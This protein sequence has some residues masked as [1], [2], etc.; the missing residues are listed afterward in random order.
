MQFLRSMIMA[1]LMVMG[2][3]SMALAEPLPA[4]LPD[5]T[6]K[7]TLPAATAKQAQ[8]AMPPKVTPLLTPA[9]GAAVD[10][11]EK[12]TLTEEVR[13]LLYEKNAFITNPDEDHISIEFTGKDAA[14][15]LATDE[16]IDHIDINP[17][18]RYFKLSV[19]DSAHPQGIVIQGHYTET[20]TLPVLVNRLKAGDII[21][22]SDLMMVTIPV[23]RLQHDTV[24][25][26][27]ELLGKT[28]RYSLTTN[29]PINEADVV[30]PVAIK[31]NDIVTLVYNNGVLRLEEKD[32][33]AME[34]GA[35]GD[36]I[37]VKKQGNG[38]LQGIVQEN[39]IVSI[40]VR[41]D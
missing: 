2:S 11:G 39:H 28:P 40:P 34:S 24:R 21:R 32:A 5:S 3:M 13:D 18:L 1:G 20:V 16:T 8:Q 36:T 38:F 22:D 17:S 12:Q 33:I 14:F 37:K 7:T 19:T 27:E 31:K 26:R 6:L 15:A 9:K 30:L 41:S 25:T 29:H 4:E 10:T 23:A 35:L